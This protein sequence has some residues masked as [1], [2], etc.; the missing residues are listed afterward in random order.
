MTSLN[1]YYQMEL[2]QGIVI[3][4]FSGLTLSLIFGIVTRIRNCWTRHK[5]ILY[6]RQILIIGRERIYTAKEGR[7]EEGGFYRNIP[8][9]SIR[10]AL[11]IEMHKDLFSALQ[12]RTSGLKYEEMYSVK[13]AFQAIDEFLSQE[14]GI[15]LHLYE[16]AFSDLE[17]RSWLNLP[18]RQG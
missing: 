14:K 18:A 13:K 2:V 16:K 10:L 4:V 1:E 17:K 8:V 7:I 12:E 15:H 3:G 5:Q 9:E 6:L 11:Y